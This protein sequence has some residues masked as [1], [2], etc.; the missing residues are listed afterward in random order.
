MSLELDQLQKNKSIS[1]I[2]DF[3]S[4]VDS[5]V[6]P[7]PSN[8]SK[9]GVSIGNSN[10]S[11][12]NVHNNS[13]LLQGVPQQTQNR[14]RFGNQSSIRMPS[15]N[16]ESFEFGFGASSHLP[17]Q[18]RCNDSWPSA[19]PLNGFSSDALPLG[20]NPFS[21][22]DLSSGVLRNN[23]SSIDPGIGSN[24]LDVSLNSVTTLQESRRNLQA[25]PIGVNVQ[26]DK[27]S[28]FVNLGDC[29]GQS[30]S[31]VPKQK[32][33]SH[34]QDYS[35]N[36]NLLFSSSNPPVPTHDVV[37]AIGQNN[38]TMSNRKTDF[39]STS[40]PNSGSAHLTRHNGIEK[41]SI[42]MSEDFLF[43]QNKSHGGV[44]SNSCGSLEDLMSAMIKRERDELTLRDG[45]MG[46]DIFPVRT[47]M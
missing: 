28:N 23:I 7:V 21:H 40:R 22:S 31:L 18:S 34:K 37:G 26:L 3:S 6:F 38:N 39:I 43:D 11:S 36:S 12:L 41:L 10:N 25:G 42:D 20:D 15:G 17:G 24:S 8:F 30:M 14:V 29:V 46:C 27:F 45:D 47:C 44:M 2:G 5:T 13:L 19:T 35:Q 32:W 9:T 1:R 16:S 33:I 4:S